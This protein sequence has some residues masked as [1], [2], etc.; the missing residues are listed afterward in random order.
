[1]GF[2]IWER[3]M[4][5]EGLKVWLLLLCG[6]FFLYMLLDYSNN[7]QSFQKSDATGFEVAFYYL[8][9]LSRNWELLAS[10]SLL[11]ASIRVLTHMNSYNEV[12]AL[13]SSGVTRKR[14]LRPLMVI[15]AV[16]AVSVFVNSEFIRPSTLA[17]MR[18]LRDETVKSARKER[19]QGRVQGYVLN[20]GSTL[21][22]QYYDT[23][24]KRFFDLYWL[25]SGD[26]AFRIKYLYP[27]DATS[28]GA[29]VDRIMRDS[30]GRFE[31]VES[32]ASY[33]FPELRFTEEDIRRNL[34]Q[35]E[36][37]PPSLLWQHLPAN[38]SRELLNDREIQI[39]ASL[40]SKLAMPWLC[41]L[42]VMAPAPF[43][44]TFSRRLP[45]FLIFGISILAFIFFLM[46]FNAMSV[47]GQNGLMDPAY[48]IWTPFLAYALI[49]GRP[50]YSME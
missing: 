2:R 5:W 30:Q 41:L 49:F 14:L 37:W 26:E 8:L 22:Y 25:R 38:R 42:V 11:L 29:Y 33:P 24:H 27:S 48:A 40:H 20:D 15:G 23:A 32:F 3:Y 45:I 44:L 6:T 36:H 18:R 19:R 46:L 13:F 16:L 47:L 21:L 9:Q 1:M 43:C 31:I 10:F 50:F 39:L 12:I 7:V 34:F 35:P 17:E 4:L 28:T